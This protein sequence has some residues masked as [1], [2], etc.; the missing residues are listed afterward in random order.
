MKDLVEPRQSDVLYETN[1]P[2]RYAVSGTVA[3]V[4]LNRPELSNSQ[5]SRMT[6]ALDG[7]FRRVADD[8]DVRVIVLKGNGKRTVMD[9]VLHVFLFTHAHN[10]RTSGNPPSDFDAKSMAA[11]QRP[12]E[13]RD[14]SGAG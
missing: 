7:A 12:K 3:A 1:E 4:S 10:D 8:D 6:N 2:V 5:N 14:G 13:P 11:S 9:A